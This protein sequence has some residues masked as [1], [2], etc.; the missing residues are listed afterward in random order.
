MLPM[1]SVQSNVLRR[2][3]V[4][5]VITIEALPGAAVYKQGM[6]RQHDVHAARWH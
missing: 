3:K 2:I 6:T 5:G 1:I 4:R